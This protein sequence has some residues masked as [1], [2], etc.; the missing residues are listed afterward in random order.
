[1][2]I[3]GD[4]G[5][6]IHKCDNSVSL[7]RSA[8]RQALISHLEFQVSHDG[9][10]IGVAAAF[11]D[12]VDRALHLDGAFT[13]RHQRIDHGAF[14][15]VVGVDAEWVLDGSFDFADDS[16]HFPGHGAAVGV[17]QND[18]FRAAANGGFERFE[19]V[20]G[21][22]FVAVKEML[23]VVD[24]A[25]VV[26][27]QIGNGLLDDAQVVFQRGEQNIGDMQRPG[28]AENG[29]D[30]CLRI[31]QRLDVGIVFGSAFDAAGGTECGDQR[32]L[33]FH[34]AGA[35]EEFNILG[36]R[37]RPAAF[38]ERHAEIVQFVA[39]CGLCHWRK[40]EAFGLGAIAQGGV[41]DLDIHSQ[42]LVTTERGLVDRSSFV[43][44]LFSRFE[45]RDFF[46]ESQDVTEFVH[47]V[48]QAGLVERIN[49]ES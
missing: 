18:R 10:E 9:D 39:R 3:G 40:R 17:A 6:F 34:V 11:A 33:P 44:S 26:G 38:D 16:F 43:Y 31:E 47:A 45:R 36:V 5:N 48:E 30:G 25:P 14:A 37:A 15:V 22:R 41:V 42:L 19:R 23:G 28:L 13:H 29:A 12:T 21:I 35:L 2:F 27:A 32:I 49:G 4:V 24:D 8:F 1:M 46:F 7:A 20:G